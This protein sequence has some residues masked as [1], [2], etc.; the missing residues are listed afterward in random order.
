MS[1]ARVVLAVLMVSF[2]VSTASAATTTYTTTADFN[3]G[4]GTGVLI[5]NDQV[6]LIV[7]EVT[8]YPTLWVANA[9]DPSL[10]KFDTDTGAELARYQSWFGNWQTYGAWSGPA[11]SRTCVDT[12]GNCYVANRHFDG[13]PASIMKVLT[14]D[15]ID[16]NGNGVLDTSY[17]ANNDGEIQRSEMFDLVDLNS[18]GYIDDNEIMDE[19]IAWIKQI[20]PAN[21]LGRCLAIDLS[22]DLWLGLFNAQQ[23]WKVNSSDGS[24]LG[25]PYAANGSPYGALVDKN[26]IL[27]SASLSSY[28]IRLDTNAATPVGVTFSHSQYSSNYG[29]ALGYDSSDNTRVYLGSSAGYTYIQ[30][31]SSTN[32]FSTPAYPTISMRTLGIATDSDGNIVVGNYYSP[33]NTVKMQPDGTLIWNSPAQVYSEV[34]GSVVD[35]DDNVW[36]IHRA[37]HQLSKFAGT[38]GASLGSFNTGQYPYTYS[39]AT[40]IG[41]R[42][43]ISVGTWNVAYDSGNDLTEWGTV[44]WNAL[45]P[46]D[47]SITVRARS[48]TDQAAWSPWESA[49][50]GTPLSTLPDGRYIEV[51][52][53]FTST[54][55]DAENPPVLYD[56]TLSGEGG[57]MITSIFEAALAGDICLFCA[58]WDPEAR[59]YVFHSGNP[60]DNAPPIPPWSGFFVNVFETSGVDLLLADESAAT[61]PTDV[62][63]DLPNDQYN[64]IASPLVPAST[65]IND[66][67]GDDLPGAFE[68]T[69]RAAKWDYAAGGVG[70]YRNYMNLPAYEGL[71][72][73]LPGR[74][75]WM[76]QLSGATQ[77]LDVS[78][79]PVPVID[80]DDTDYRELWLASNGSESTLHMAGNPFTEQIF[81]QNSLVRTPASATQIPKVAVEPGDIDSW[82][83]GVSLEALTGGA[84]DTYN[85]AG[86]IMTDGINP[87]IF[88][89]TDLD[90]MGEYVRVT[91]HDPSFDDV[92]PLAYD[93]RPSGAGE[94]RWEI[95]LSTSY[96]TIDARFVLDNLFMVPEGYAITLLDMMSN[97]VIPLESD[98]SGTVALSSS[99]TRTFLLTVTPM[100]TAVDA[101]VPASFGIIGVY[102]NPFNASATIQ[103][104]M[105]VTGQVTVEIYNLAGQHI[106][107]LVDG[108]QSAGSHNTVWRADAY[109]TGVY[110]AVI[111]SH[112]RIDTRKLTY[113]K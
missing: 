102:P 1:I 79:T 41:L 91:L 111:K 81:W 105:A 55:G 62:T 61:E 14:S 10:S 103:Y 9:G 107:T 86:V 109:A 38:N 59:Q 21:G 4:I 15:W 32:T 89:I 78:G 48:S 26:G 93:F 82:H 45:E 98:Y 58:T 92:S 108:I 88:C 16:R 106:D 28:L 110:V 51:E 56:L 29:L 6:E 31:D 7:G 44:S 57:T 113:V 50:N 12:D 37:A 5:D 24:V 64:L 99:N 30:F 54:S 2:L 67:F 100:I 46:D 66:N 83:I 77:T 11:P 43:S 49:M 63:F 47:T 112:N 53:K 19:R 27:W 104:T 101:S 95:E 87:D 35:S 69:W 72:E 18:N 80:I 22:G 23:F 25:G 84:K 8:T 13:R 65:D 40:G 68:S 20:G 33:Y 96:D 42:T 70:A 34:R 60:Q 39:D 52:V 97:E 74:G 90:P 75:F 73:L 17:D 36:Q 3:E 71:M 85:R 76:L 94:F